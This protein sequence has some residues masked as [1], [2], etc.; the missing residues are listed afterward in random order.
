MINDLSYKKYYTILG[1]F[2]FFSFFLPRFALLFFEEKEKKQM[3]RESDHHFF[4]FFFF[5]FPDHF[6][7]PIIFSL[8]FFSWTRVGDCARVLFFLFMSSSRESFSFFRGHASTS[9]HY[10]ALRK[11]RRRQGRL[12]M[13]RLAITTDTEPLQVSRTLNIKANPT[14]PLLTSL[15][16]TQASTSRAKGLAKKRSKKEMLFFFLLR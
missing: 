8:F 1:D 2:C 16:T 9:V 4:L 5:S 11:H 15:S 12:S 6:H 14:F 3:R 10:E 7:F 13:T